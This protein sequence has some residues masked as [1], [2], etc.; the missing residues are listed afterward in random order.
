MKK[1]IQ[2]TED[3]VLKV[4]QNE[5]PSIHFVEKSNEKLK[6]RSDSMSNLIFHNLKFPKKMFKNTNIL[7]VGAG[8]GDTSIIFNHWGAN[9]TLV[10][11]NY[12]AIKRAKM[13]FKKIALKKTKN[14]FIK[15]SIFNLK[16][17]KKFDIV[18][19]IGVVHHT[20]DPTYALERISKYV[21]KEGYL[22]IGC[23][24]PEGFFQRNLQRYIITCFANLNDEESIE[25]IARHLFK[26]HLLRA[27]K[28][29]KRT[30]K[31]IVADTYINPKIHCLNPIKINKALKKEF[32]FYSSAP[33]INSYF[34]PDSPLTYKSDYFINMKNLTLLN[35]LTWMHNAGQYNN[36]LK[37]DNKN[38]RDLN[39][40][41]DKL[42]NIFN[43]FNPETKINKKKINKILLK[44]INLCK[45]NLIQTD[46]LSEHKKFLL[47]VKLLFKNL[48]K[49]DINKTKVFLDKCKILFK[50][51]SGLGNNYYIYQKK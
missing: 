9:C 14:K 42:S 41:T 44:K 35:C 8:T 21:K 49:K 32:I 34:N 2:L 23:A 29:G 6:N 16:L 19:S 7:D 51:S 17:K 38:L 31:A 40:L 20:E 4:Y 47:E 5:N 50:K 46:I 13:I 27:N 26:K 36:L 37:N 1:N 12:K 22:I 28:Y 48:E 43:N 30:I 45:N 24:S 18:T 39:S 15:S 10:D 25:K 3:K 11:M 33:S